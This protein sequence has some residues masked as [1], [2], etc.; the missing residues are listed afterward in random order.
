MYKKILLT[1]FMV[2]ALSGYADA[3][4]HYIPKDH[5]VI[6]TYGGNPS[7]P[8][9]A[10]NSEITVLVWNIYKGKIVGWEEDFRELS[11]NSDILILQEAFINPRM[12]R[13]FNSMENHSFVM[14]TAWEDT[15]YSNTKSGVATA[16]KVKTYDYSW[17][18]SLYREPIVKTPKMTLFTEYKIKNSRKTLLVGN[19]HGINFVSTSKLEHMLKEAAKRLVEHDGPTI[20][21]G[22]FNTWNDYKT[23]AMNKIFESIGMRAVSFSPDG[24]KKFRGNILDHIWVKDIEV[25]KSEVLSKIGTSDHKAM[26]V[27]LKL[28]N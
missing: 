7:S 28:Q 1:L 19:I 14:A 10:L 5:E 21:A 18:R 22:D 2:S 11:K 6:S 4:R 17:Q 26:S 20:I 12:K 16:S 8:A 9:V 27:I 13:V 24:R 15:K 23:Y 25:L 3:G